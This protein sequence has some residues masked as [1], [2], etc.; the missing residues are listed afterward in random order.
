[1][2]G[3]KMSRIREYPEAQ[4]MGDDEYLVID[5]P[6][7]VKK[8]KRSAVIG[9]IPSPVSA[10]DFSFKT[11]TGG[12]RV[13]CSAA[14]FKSIELTPPE[15]DGYTPIGIVSHYCLSKITNK[16]QSTIYF[17]FDI[18]GVHYDNGKWYFDVNITT[19][20]NANYYNLGSDEAGVTWMYVKE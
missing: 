7:G 13:D 4:S 8:I 19:A 18:Y 12:I 14:G 9:E 17:E 3:V 15:V 16:V 6:N 2:K 10:D 1:M 20:R 11:A 5:G